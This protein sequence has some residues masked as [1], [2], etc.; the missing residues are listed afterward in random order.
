MRRIPIAILP[1]LLLLAGCPRAGEGD[2][3]PATRVDRGSAPTAETFQSVVEEVLP[4]IV[5]IQAE[6]RAP[7]EFGGLVPGR[8]DQLMPL[9]VGSGV[10]YSPEGYIL[11]N[12]HVVQQADRVTVML[13]DRRQLEARVV[14]RDPSTDVAVVKVE[15]R[16]FPHARLGDSDAVRLGD[17]VLA[18]GSPLGLEFTVTAGI[19]SG[20]GRS[21]GILAQGMRPDESGAAPLEHFIQTD[22]AINPGNSGGP[23]VNMAGE[24]IG[25]NTAIATPGGGFAGYGFA[26]PSNLAERVA[27]QLVEHG[28]VRRPYLGVLL[29]NVTAADAEVYGLDR[30]E[31]AEVKTVEAGGPAAQAGLQIGDVVLEIEGRPVGTVADLQARLAQLEPG[32]TVRLR[33]VRF[34]QEREVAVRL[35]VVTSGVRPAPPPQEPNGPGQL[36]FVVG[37]RGGN[38]IVTGVRPFS[39][40]MR[41]GVQTGQVILSV[42]QREVSSP[43]D[44]VRAVERGPAEVVSLVVQDPRVGRTIINYRTQ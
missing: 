14:A 37:Q 29:A 32:S 8:G 7:A 36:G 2:A 33:T 11:T 44:L 26:I 41:A 19:V 3:P 28:E 17:W 43:A 4:A 16:D 10:L 34:G 27:E 22:A 20:T 42:N 5:F 31:G 40:A 30:A 24:V 38:V 9:G 39:A 1:F 21:L 15:G 35:G 23:L 12:N 6:G 13:Y 18:L 25:I